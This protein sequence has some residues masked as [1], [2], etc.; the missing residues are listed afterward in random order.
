V[1][2]HAATVGD[3]N[4]R[5]I[6][7]RASDIGAEGRGARRTEWGPW[8]I[9]R[10]ACVLWTT[11]PGYRYEVDLEEC[12][13]SA[14]T[15]DWIFQVAGKQWQDRDRIIA[16]LVTALGDVLN[17]QAHLCPSGQPRQLSRAAIRKLAGGAGVTAR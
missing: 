7:T 12:T 6:L 17:P 11:A 14:R 5:L 9:D 13:T 8:D 10:T 3:M 1:T 2:S 15:M 16:G 4:R